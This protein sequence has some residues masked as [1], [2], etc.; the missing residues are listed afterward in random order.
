MPTY[1]L[2]AAYTEESLKTLAE[3]PEDR[4]QVVAAQIEKLGGRLVGFY[5]CFGEYYDAVVICELP[6][7][8][9]AQALAVSIS[10]ASHTKALKISRLTG[11][12]EAMEVM[13]KAGSAPYHRPGMS[14]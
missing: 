9:S 10:A 13:R 6:D 5:H 14:R 4:G 2:Q 8:M 1:M 7:E 11:V 12:N 3:R